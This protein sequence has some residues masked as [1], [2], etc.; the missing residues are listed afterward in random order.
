MIS[1]TRQL[2]TKVQSSKDGVVYYTKKS[3][4]LKLVMDISVEKKQLIIKFAEDNKDI[5]A[6]KVICKTCQNE[7][8]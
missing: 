1:N 6:L 3:L 2:W 4:F 5:A 7:R 8:R